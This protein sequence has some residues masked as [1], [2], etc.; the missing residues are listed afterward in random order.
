MDAVGLWARRHSDSGME[1]NRWMPLGC[2]HGDIQILAWE[3]IGG[4]RWVVGTAT[5]RFWHGKKSVDA[6]PLHYC[7]TQMTEKQAGNLIDECEQLIKIIAKSIVT[8]KEK[9]NK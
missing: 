4:C 6:V 8:S 5:F 9:L 2:G 7:N 1:K 3:K